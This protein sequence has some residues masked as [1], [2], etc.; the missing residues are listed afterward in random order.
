MKKRILMLA[1]VAAAVGG[2]FLYRRFQG[3]RRN[4]LSFSG[5]IEMNEIRLAFKRAGRLEARLVDEG[6]MVTSGAL[7]GR[8]DVSEL[9]RQ[10]EKA[11]A[12]VQAASSTLGTLDYA[13]RYA[14]ENLGATVQGRQADLAQAEAGLR[15]MRTGSRR[16]EIATAQ[17]AL[18]SAR[19]EE[20]QARRDWE[21][22]RGLFE[23]GV[24]SRAQYDAARTRYEAAQSA[25]R[26]AQERLSLVKEGPRVEQIEAARAMVDKAKGGLRG[27]QALE[28]DLQSKRQ[29][30]RTRQ[31]QLEQALADLALIQTQLAE[32]FLYAP[33]TGVILSKSAESGEVLAAGTPVVTLGDLDH[34]WVRA[35]IPE[36]DL[37]RVQLGDPVDVRTD[38]FLG[39]TYKGRVAYIASE[40]EFTPKQIQTR[41]ERTKLVYRVKVE[42]PNPNHELKLNMPV[43]GE[44]LPQRPL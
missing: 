29:E 6:Q 38:S 25:V 44:I 16:Q 41:E 5:N 24:V 17:A 36:T 35:Y 20:G 13:I 22:M 9:V 14:E 30:R 33:T 39:K 26:Q 31:A 4:D 3:E 23:S 32:S 42:L 7:V 21:R 10:R 40:A 15:E 19:V 18:E 34:P 12:A 2:F 28:I 43:E 8:L 37:G 27:A 1:V 11:E